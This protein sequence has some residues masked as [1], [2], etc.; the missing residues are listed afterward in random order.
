MVP[1]IMIMVLS[2]LMSMKPSLLVSNIRKAILR[3]ASLLSFIH[4]INFDTGFH[5]DFEVEYS[6]KALYL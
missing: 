5:L 4:C 1:S 6:E 3:S 2:S